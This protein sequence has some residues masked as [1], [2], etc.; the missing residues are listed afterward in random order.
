MIG[1]SGVGA[2][3]TLRKCIA[4]LPYNLPVSSEVVCELLLYCLS[5]GRRQSVLE[6]LLSGYSGSRWLIM[7]T[8]CAVIGGSY[9]I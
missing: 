6:I 3:Q 2:G 9:G 8:E 4:E 1:H 5:I 7:H